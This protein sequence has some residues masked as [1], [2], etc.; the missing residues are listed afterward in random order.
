MATPLPDQYKRA[1][2]E[3]QDESTQYLFIVGVRHGSDQRG[4]HTG[5]VEAFALYKKPNPNLGLARE[6]CEH[7]RNAP[8][9][10]C[11]NCEQLHNCSNLTCMLY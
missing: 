9:H 5:G 6:Q 1:T 2:G 8:F 10:N 11:S 3:V 7:V 4:Q